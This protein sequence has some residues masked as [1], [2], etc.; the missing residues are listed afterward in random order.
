MQQH[1]EDLLRLNRKIKQL[2]GRNDYLET[3]S[4]ELETENQALKMEADQIRNN[5]RKLSELALQYKMQLEKETSVREQLYV[6]NQKHKERHRM[7][8]D[9][10]SQSAE[11]AKVL[12]HSLK[13]AVSTRRITHVPVEIIGTVS[14]IGKSKEWEEL[15]IKCDR[16]EKDLS[17]T[18]AIIDDLEFELESID[19]LEDENERLQQEI[20]NLRSDYRGS[21]LATEF[22][23]KDAD[24]SSSVQRGGDRVTSSTECSDDTTEEV[25]ERRSNSARKFRLEDL[26][27]KLETLHVRHSVRIQTSCNQ[28]RS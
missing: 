17:G 9:R 5:N 16:L 10:Y 23:A 18:Y 2:I 20:K 21:N 27:R 8:L 19:Y 28:N 26:H 13:S 6:A 14:D 3:R 22:P 7:L 11:E 24:K 15:K 4:A 25:I 12:R 1:E